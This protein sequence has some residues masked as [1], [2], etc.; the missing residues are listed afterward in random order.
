[1]ILYNRINSL[2]YYS[3]SLIA[4]LIGFLSIPSIYCFQANLIP[5][6]S[7]P[8]VE[9]DI[10]LRLNKH[11][12]SGI[13]LPKIDCSKTKFFLSNPTLV[14]KE[15]AKVCI[16]SR[17]DN[18]FL[19][20]DGTFNLHP[21]ATLG[22]FDITPTIKNF[23]LNPNAA[24]TGTLKQA[25]KILKHKGL[26]LRVLDRYAMDSLLPNDKPI[27]VTNKIFYEYNLVLCLNIPKPGDILDTLS[28]KDNQE[29]IKKFYTE[30][31]PHLLELSFF[32]KDSFLIGEIPITVKGEIN[33][34]GYTNNLFASVNN[35]HFKV[36]L[37][38]PL[39]PFVVAALFI[40]A[41][42][43]FIKATKYFV[44]TLHS[45][46]VK[47]TQ[48]HKTYPN[49]TSLLKKP[50][51]LQKKKLRI[52]KKPLIFVKKDGNNHKIFCFNNGL[53]FEIATAPS[54]TSK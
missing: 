24:P 27:A 37:R 25:I 53:I 9:L 32:N 13:L 29:E 10:S 46:T 5:Y 52:N 35:T 45:R 4:A 34:D 22:R 21:S 50:T 47:I 43:C 1:M 19:T 2:R 23:T 38:E 48:K 51:A 12:P 7:S 15:H 11:H 8:S 3:K 18:S 33:R 42:Q 31:K 26:F 30:K 41:L 6:A 16:Q 49:K 20:L 14:K 44:K 36:N 39:Y 17:N 28:I 54:K 40:P